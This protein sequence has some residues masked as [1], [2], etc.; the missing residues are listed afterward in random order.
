MEFSPKFTYQLTRVK[1]EPPDTACLTEQGQEQ[2]QHCSESAL[3]ADGVT[4]GMLCHIKQE[5]SDDSSNDQQIIEVK[6]EPYNTAIPMEQDQTGH[7]HDPTSE[8]AT[9]STGII[10]IKDELNDICD[11]FSL[12]CCSSS[13]QFTINTTTDNFV[14]VTVNDHTTYSDHRHDAPDQRNTPKEGQFA[15]RTSEPLKDKK[16]TYND[17]CHLEVELKTRKA[18]TLSCDTCSA[19]FRHISTLRLHAKLHTGEASYKCS[20]CTLAYV[21]QTSLKC[22]MLE[23]ASNEP[24]QHLIESKDGD[25]LVCDSGSAT[26][27]CSESV[28]NHWKM[29]TDKKLHRCSFCPAEFSQNTQLRRH[30]QTHTGEKPHKCRLCAATFARPGHLTNHMR[31]HTYGKPCKCKFCPAEFINLYSLRNHERTHTGEKPFK[32]DICPAEFSQNT[33]L[34][35]HQR[36]HTGEKP[37]KC[38]LCPAEFTQMHHLKDHVRVHTGEKPYKCDLCHA[39]FIRR[40]HLKRHEEIHAKEKPYKCR[41]CSATSAHED[42]LPH[43]TDTHHRVAI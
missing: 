13:T 16:H 35:R 34:R 41:Y 8:D 20:L 11:P 23:H 19:T 1:S 3:E 18:R 43:H 14:P 33:N 15:S 21:S 26:L 29:H 42:H 36:T 7:C 28:R 37:Y 22:H 2:Q 39:R 31:T 40:T 27:S 25:S 10:R 38:D 4:A 30:R 9:A 17:V 6:T 32:C 12:G 24:E 5:P